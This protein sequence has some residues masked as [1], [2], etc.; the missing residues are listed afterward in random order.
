MIAKEGTDPVYGARPIRRVI[1]KKIEASFADSVIS[2]DIN[3][4]DSLFAQLSDEGDIIWKK[5]LSEVTCGALSES[6]DDQSGSGGSGE[7]NAV[8]E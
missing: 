7:K 3:P 2:G 6:G 8:E 4:G 5:K 1:Q